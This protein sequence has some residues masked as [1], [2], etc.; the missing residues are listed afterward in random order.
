M[1]GDTPIETPWGPTCG[2]RRKNVGPPRPRFHSE[3]SDTVG[4]VS[5][6]KDAIPQ[7]TTVFPPIGFWEKHKNGHEHWS[8]SIAGTSY[9]LTK[10]NSC[11][12]PG[13]KYN[14]SDEWSKYTP[15]ACSEKLKALLQYHKEGVHAPSRSHAPF[16]IKP[17]FRDN[18]L[19]LD[20]VYSSWFE[21]APITAERLRKFYDLVLVGPKTKLPYLTNTGGVAVSWFLPDLVNTGTFV[22]VTTLSTNGEN[23]VAQPKN[24]M[25][26]VPCQ[27]AL[28]DDSVLANWM[29]RQA[30]GRG[31][32]IQETRQ[33]FICARE[34]SLCRILRPNF[35]RSMH[36]A[37]QQANVDMLLRLAAMRAT[38]EMVEG[39]VRNIIR[40]WEKRYNRIGPF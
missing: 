34:S 9:F 32:I 21:G 33:L 6:R 28:Y 4:G 23:I 2:N 12:Q 25:C 26:T 7:S 27:K 5:Q 3:S 14:E 19:L 10:E 40:E 39:I 16:E 22:A 1:V 37:D 35:R 11:S 17:T 18:R 20:A 29:L 36:F 31:D 38:P 8:C 30:S 13:G 15:E 24:R